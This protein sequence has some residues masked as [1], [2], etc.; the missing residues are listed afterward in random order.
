[1]MLYDQFKEYAMNMAPP[2]LV[3]CEFMNPGLISHGLLTIANV[4]ILHVN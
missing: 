3:R 2:L 1:M 4:G